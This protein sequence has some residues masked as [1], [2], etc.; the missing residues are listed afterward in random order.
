MAA[1]SGRYEPPGAP[2][3]GKN[4]YYKVQMN[5]SGNKIWE[6]KNKE[7]YPRMGVTSHIHGAL[8]DEFE[9]SRRAAAA[10]GSTH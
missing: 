6:N 9:R 3:G 4:I 5:E 10:S 8:I 1:P 2:R 7:G